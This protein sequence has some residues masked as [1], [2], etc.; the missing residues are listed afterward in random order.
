MIT[1]QTKT[2]PATENKPVSVIASTEKGETAW[3]TFSHE[4]SVED[5]HRAA[6]SALAMALGWSPYT[7][8][9]QSPVSITFKQRTYWSFS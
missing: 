1:I 6:A 7:F 3:H 2:I 5:N 9:A 4:Y 8:G